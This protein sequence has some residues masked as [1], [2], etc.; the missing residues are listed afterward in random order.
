MSIDLG[1]IGLLLRETRI[2]KGLTLV[3]VSDALFLRKSVIEAIESGDWNSLPHVV[4]VKGYVKEYSAFLGI[5]VPT[6]EETLENRGTVFANR[7][8]FLIPER[9][10][11]WITKALEYRTKLPKVAVVVPIIIIAAVI[12][13]LLANDQRKSSYISSRDE[14]KSKVPT[15][16]YLNGAGKKAYPDLS[17]GKHLMVTCHER[18]WISVIIDGAE[19][20][21]FMLSPQEVVVLNAKD[22]FDLLIGNAGGVSLYLDG[23]SVDFVGK[24]GEVKR[25]RLS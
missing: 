18:T 8:E 20:K 16:A 11:G 4:Y 25:I 15:A 13:I 12:G 17:E 9:P 23:K 5:E 19:K 1:K 14:G 7:D 10:P 21:E 22:R 3:Q 24:S 2:R 6:V